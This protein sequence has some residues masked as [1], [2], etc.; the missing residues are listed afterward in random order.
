V[1]R[2]GDRDMW[3]AR[4]GGSDARSVALDPAELPM[5]AIALTEESGAAMSDLTPQFLA[6]PNAN[7]MVMTT[8]TDYGTLHAAGRPQ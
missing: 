8:A 4:N 3:A 1:R 7:A 6:G 5:S 2:F